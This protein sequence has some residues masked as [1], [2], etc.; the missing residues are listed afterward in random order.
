MYNE[1]NV[2]L[3]ELAFHL[4]RGDE[5]ALWQ[6]W[7][8]VK[9]FALAVVRRYTPTSSIDVDDLLQCAF[10]G[11]RTAA[12]A[13]DGRYAFLNLIA[14]AIRRECRRALSLDRRREPDCISYDT[15]M[16][17]NPEDVSFLD[18]YA[19]ESL[20]ESSEALELEELRRDV[21][22]AVAALPDRQRGIIKRHYFDGVT[23]EEIAKEQGVTRER[24]RQI[25][26]RAFDRLRR[27][28]ILRTI[29]RP[30]PHRAFHPDHA[31]RRLSPVEREALWNLEQ[32]QKHAQ[33]ARKR[34]MRARR[35]LL[36]ELVAEGY[37]TQQDADQRM[38]EMLEG[39]ACNRHFRQP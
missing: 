7:E 23:L 37:L 2:F 4:Q 18:G 17:D 29:Y 39:V 28:R 20:P 16:G 27:D 19:D 13:H 26:E 21:Q 35:K 14:W 12:F 24:I 34:E 3:E 8:H 5:S 30:A 6:L 25:E 10:L 1:N 33:R 32:E 11:V 22:E 15:P 9:R 31:G 36:Q 38:R